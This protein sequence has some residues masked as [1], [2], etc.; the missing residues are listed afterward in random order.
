MPRL[1]SVRCRIKY[2]L[3]GGMGGYIC[4]CVCVCERTCKSFFFPLEKKNVGTKL[5]TGEEEKVG[6]LKCCS[7]FGSF[8]FAL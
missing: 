3:K 2:R 8:S 4:V 6:V 1:L 7:R 5:V